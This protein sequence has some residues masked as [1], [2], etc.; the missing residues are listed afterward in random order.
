MW[1]RLPAA[2]SGAFCAAQPLFLR[3]LS[4]SDRPLW[5]LS[6]IPWIPMY[7]TGWVP[8]LHPLIAPGAAIAATARNTV[9]REHASE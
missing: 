7:A 1:V 4:R 9:G 5:M 8:P 2:G 6:L 3:N